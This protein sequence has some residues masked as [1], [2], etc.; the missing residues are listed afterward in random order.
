[1]KTPATF[2]FCSLP[3]FALCLVVA[4]SVLAQPAPQFA[5]VQCLTNKEVNLKLSNPAG[6]FQRLEVSGNLTD[7]VPLANLPKTTGTLDYTDSATPYLPARFYR[8]WQLTDTTALTGDYLVTSDGPVLIQ[9]INHATLVMG[10][11]DKTVYVDPVGGSARFPGIPKASL[12]LVTHEHTDHFDSSTIAA[13]RATNAIIIAPKT[14]YAALPGALKTNTIMLTNGMATNVLGLAVEAIPAYNI[15]SSYHVKGI[16]NGYL[17]TI[18]GKRIYL[19]G[20]TDD[21]PEMRALRDIDIS[22]LSMNQPYTMTVAK[23]VSATREFRP[24]VVYPYHSQG[25]D[26]N[27]YKRQVGTDLGIEVRLRKWY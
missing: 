22:F 16:G 23:A 2:S 5:T 3:R 6:R 15:G 9:P 12:V 26:V 25:T 21:T 8:A 24:K 20:D 27:S 14:V 7:W 10:W 18:G 13:I 17:L 19:S 1:M 4:G 11:N